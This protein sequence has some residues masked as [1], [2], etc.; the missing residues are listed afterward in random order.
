MPLCAAFALRATQGLE[1]VR[2]YDKRLH[3]RCPEDGA[4]GAATADHGRCVRLEAIENQARGAGKRNNPVF[5]QALLDASYGTYSDSV[6]YLALVDQNGNLLA[7]AEKSLPGSS[8]TAENDDGEIYRYEALLGRPRNPRREPNPSVAGWRMRIG[9]YAA[10][11]D[12]IRR[13]AYLQL[14]VS[15]LTIA[16]LIALSAYL[17]RM[18]HRFVELKVREGAE[19]QLRS[20]GM[21]AAS[22][23]HEIR[24]PLGA[25]KGLTQL[26]QEDL[27]PDNEAQTRLRTVVREAERLERLVTDLLEFARPKEPQISDFDLMDLLSDVKAMLHGKLESSGVALSF[28]REPASL[29]IRS[30]P[31][32]LRQ[33]LLNV[34]LNAVDASPAGSTVV[35]S[36]N[37]NGNDKSTAIQIDDAG[38]GLGGR[39]PEELFQPFVTTKVRGTGLGLAV[40]HQI[41]ESLGGSLTLEDNPQGGTRCTIHLRFP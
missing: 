14:G 34:I 27:A 35:L 36:I 12:F 3:K 7:H 15:G 19:A 32:G 5:W 23:A 29:N 16:V 18:L 4:S 11:A 21:M 17:M 9:L 24:N 1:E 37:H 30:D 33:V 22:L 8:K 2:T 13:L 38:P 10:D 41:M 26:A 40:S 28:S 20:L 39:N 31:G 6:A 25:M